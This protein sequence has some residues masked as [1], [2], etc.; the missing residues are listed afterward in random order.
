MS[1]IVDDDL[2]RDSV[3]DGHVIR[4]ESLAYPQQLRV[5]LPVP[6][7]AAATVRRGRR[8]I[9]AVLA[10]ADDRL[11]VITGPCS[12]HDRE[13]ALDYARRLN[14]LVADLAGDLVVVMR[15]YFEKPRTTVGW[16]GLINDPHLD[17]THDVGAGLMTAR[18]FL[19]EVGTIGLPAA[20]EWLEP[21]TPQFLA[22]LVSWAA[23]G[24]RTSESQIHRQLASGL[25]MPVGFKNSTD[26][27][28]PTAV[29]GACAARRGQS[30]LGIDKTGRAALV[31]TTGNRDTHLVLR[32]GRRGPNYG[33]DQ[34]A[35]AAARAAAAGLPGRLIVDASHGNSGKD[36]HRQAQ[37]ACELA[38]QI[39]AGNSAIAG[40]ML[41]G[42]LV[43]GAQP[44]TVPLDH[45]L[46]Y[47]QS[48]TDAC[49]SWDTPADLLTTLAEA[50]RERRRRS[51]DPIGYRG[52]RSNND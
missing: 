48:V 6:A 30:F 43:A 35:A 27:D 9:A 32:G 20:T 49:L 17:G 5:S 18:R 13:A 11:V 1:I 25:S 16:K 10:G 41:E 7:K 26:G 39:A 29:D 24:A 50:S 4:F 46:V 40:L 52:G 12:I 22:E 47:G 38:A 33:A 14:T 44:L 28:V 37:V 42:F 21:I 2:H 45:E 34:V 19:I 36:H 3:S 23:I 51:Q 31:T 15:C 8:D